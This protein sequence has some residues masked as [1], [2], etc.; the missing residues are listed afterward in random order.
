MK[1]GKEEGTRGLR[2][3]TEGRKK[4]KEEGG[5]E[6]ERK[7]GRK[8][9][10]KL[11][12]GKEEKRDGGKRPNIMDRKQIDLSPT[13]HLKVLKNKQIF[14]PRA[15]CSGKVKQIIKMTK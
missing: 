10:E 15:T 2:K 11:E 1:E 9:G 4:K 8:R 13:V 3:K 12:G 7:K 14:K 6:K 5:M